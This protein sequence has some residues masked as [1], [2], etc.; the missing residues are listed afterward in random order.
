MLQPPSQ[1]FWLDKEGKG[2]GHWCELVP[3]SPASWPTFPEHHYRPLP[4]ILTH[5][6][7]KGELLPV[8]QLQAMVDVS[9]LLGVEAARA[10][11]EH[12]SVS[13]PGALLPSRTLLYLGAS[14]VLSP[15]LVSSS[16]LNVWCFTDVTMT[17]L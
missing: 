14:I 4:P 13:S 3:W 16:S 8:M 9:E 10:G 5:T 6:G 7:W 12:V 1:G 11:S 2:L 15:L 17:L